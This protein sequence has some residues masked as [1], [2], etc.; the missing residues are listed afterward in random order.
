MA[1]TTTIARPYAEALFRLADQGGR[2]KD[3]SATLEAMSRVAADAQMRECIA[4]PRL[5]AAALAEL[6]VS[7]CEGLDAQA[8][9]LV[10]V[11]VENRRLAL[12]P[13]IRG[14][15]EALKNER[16]GVLKAQV[17]SAFPL[18]EAQKAALVSDLE[19]KFGQKVEATVALDPELIGGVKVAVGDEVIDAS[20][21]A[22]LAAMAAALKA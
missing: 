4:N 7:L 22:K 10:R 20:V 8:R 19:R 9:S 2:L 21:R 17:F 16:E 12:L 1:E 6:F 18:D 13:E 11:L 3:W 14:Q 5:S 15:F